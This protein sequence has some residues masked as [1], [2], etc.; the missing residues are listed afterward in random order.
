MSIFVRIRENAVDVDVLHFGMVADL[1][2]SFLPF[3]LCASKA[4]FF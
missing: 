4:L 3:L 1:F 2:S